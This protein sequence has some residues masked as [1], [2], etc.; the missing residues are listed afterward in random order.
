MGGEAVKITM[1]DFGGRTVHVDRE[2]IFSTVVDGTRYEA[3]TLVGLRDAVM[4]RA[5]KRPAEA[6]I[7]FT[8]IEG[9]VIRHGTA[10]GIRRIDGTILVTWDDTHKPG[11]VSWS[12]RTMRRL[13]PADA[14][15]YRELC[16][17]L[18]A[19]RHAVE[20]FELANGINLKD[21]ISAA[22]AAS[23]GNGDGKRTE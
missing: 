22:L 10:T 8:V 2:G 4:F 6:R 16:A 9:T 3:D 21:A 17:D 7:P 14:D 23:N 13:G 15:A 20:K 19:A 11:V 12:H 18:D 5:Y 1:S